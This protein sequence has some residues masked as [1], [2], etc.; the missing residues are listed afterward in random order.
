MSRMA[1]LAVAVLLAGGQVAMGTQPVVENLYV[2]EGLD[3][4]IEETTPHTYVDI[5]DTN[6]TVTI[7]SGT[8]FI[9][10][11]THTW[12]NSF[13]R[14]RPIIGV[15]APAEGPLATSSTLKNMGNWVVVTAGGTLDVKLQV[16]VESSTPFHGDV[17]T[18]S[19]TWTLIV[20]P[21]EPPA[22]AI[23]S[24]GLIVMLGL[25][26]GAGGLVLAKRRVAA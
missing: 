26:L 5:P 13:C 9:T 15:D 11:S 8:A 22:P 3:F 19:I 10:W 18:S 2:T 6:K 25:L 12:T 1:F 14:V 23:S 16:Q 24:V 7:P 17:D 20:F 4:M 21:D